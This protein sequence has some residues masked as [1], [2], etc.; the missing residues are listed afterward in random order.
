MILQKLNEL[1]PIHSD[2]QAFHP[3]LM[4]LYPIAVSDPKDNTLAIYD[5]D[6]SDT[7]SFITKGIS[8][9]FLPPRIRASFPIEF[10]ESRC[11]CVVS[12]DI[13]DEADGFVTF[14]HEFVH[15]YQ[16]EHG[17]E[18]IK[19]SLSISQKYDDPNWELNHPFP[20]EE[21]F[22]KSA[23]L[24]IVNA[25]KQDESSKLRKRFKEL[26]LRLEKYDYEYMIWQMWKEGFARFIENRIREKYKLKRNNFGELTQYNRISFYYLGDEI[27]SCL[28]RLDKSVIIDIERL[29]TILYNY[30]FDPKIS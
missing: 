22:F 4:K 6:L 18:K 28:H 23:F 20:Y 29:F 26:R 16:Y 5:I 25:A 24:E 7:Y 13:F 8:D 1:I 9:F 2:M 30:E 14:F 15:C 12:P 17:E 10:Y 19:K 27:I 21:E 3:S 11:C